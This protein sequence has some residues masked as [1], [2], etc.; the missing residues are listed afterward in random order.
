MGTPTWRRRVAIIAPLAAA[1]ALFVTVGAQA[2][3]EIGNEM[4]NDFGYVSLTYGET[5]AL[6][7]A[8]TGTQPCEV[9]L[10]FFDMDGVAYTGPDMRPVVI[11]P[12]TGAAVQLDWRQFGVAAPGDRVAFRPQVDVTPVEGRSGDGC[13]TVPALQVFE[14]ASGDTSFVLPGV[15]VGFNPQPD[16]P[17]QPGPDSH[18]ER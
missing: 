1:A 3:Q 15:L 7:V 9:T 10:G 11:Q 6:S 2:I 5:A 16:P 4:P 13:E 14:Q 17:G 12:G 8:N 18:S